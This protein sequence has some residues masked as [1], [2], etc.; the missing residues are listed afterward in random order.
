[1]LINGANGGHQT[2]IEESLNARAKFHRGL[3]G[4]TGHIG[5]Q[6]ATARLN[7]ATAFGLERTDGGSNAFFGFREAEINLKFDAAPKLLERDVGGLFQEGPRLAGTCL[8]FQGN[9]PGQ[10]LFLL[11]QTDEFTIGDASGCSFKFL[12]GMAKGLLDD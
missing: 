1:M 11:H 8:K 6:G 4:G 12:R 3:L 9:F 5:F 10:G 2:R 7:S